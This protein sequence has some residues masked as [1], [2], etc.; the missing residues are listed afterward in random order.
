MLL[1]SLMAGEIIVI[2]PARDFAGVMVQSLTSGQALKE[3]EPTLSQEAQV[4]TLTFEDVEPGKYRVSY[5]DVALPV[6][7]IQVLMETLVTVGKETTTT[8]YL[9]RPHERAQ[10]M[11]PKDIEDF[12]KRHRDNLL[13]LTAVYD[14]SKVPFVQ[15]REG[16]GAINYLRN[17]CEYSLK[18]WNHSYREF[19]KD[20]HVIYEKTFR[21]VAR[22]VDPFAPGG[23]PHGSEN[24]S[25]EGSAQPTAKPADDSPE[26]DQPAT[27]TS[28]D[29]Y[30]P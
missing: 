25:E 29:E 28:K 21:T 9:F 30:N 2:Y 27:P 24:K 19:P 7:Y 5:S 11:L 22:E 23:V 20:S 1:S 4:S 10:L 15:V 3:T 6:G 26:K 18:V 14:G 17:D 16:V 8:V 12:L 13:E